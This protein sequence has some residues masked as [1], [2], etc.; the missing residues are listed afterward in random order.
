MAPT[1]LSLRLG[2]CD[3]ESTVRFRV[4]FRRTYSRCASIRPSGPIDKRHSIPT[5]FVRLC[6]FTIKP[7]SARAGAHLAQRPC[8]Y[9]QLSARRTHAH[10]CGRDAALC[11]HPRSDAR[12]PCPRPHSDAH[13]LAA[14][15]RT[16]GAGLFSNASSSRA[17]DERPLAP[18]AT[19]RA[20]RASASAGGK[21][22]MP[23][24]SCSSRARAGTRGSTSSSSAN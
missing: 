17:S 20:R 13:A 21:Q 24:G 23:T 7:L 9:P 12:T 8:V 6:P 18:S 19:A 22:A 16:A 1:I 15:R 3:L 5:A 4:V 11:P 10:N 2:V 14:A